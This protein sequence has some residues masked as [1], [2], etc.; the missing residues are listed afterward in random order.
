MK[1]NL[2]KKDSINEESSNININEIIEEKNKILE[3]KNIEENSNKISLYIVTNNVENYDLENEYNEE[4]LKKLL[5]PKETQRYFSKNNYPTFY[6]IGLQEIVKLNTSN[7]I[8]A[9]N[10]NYVNLWETKI[11]QLLQKNYNYT[12][13]YKE[14]LVGV[15][16]LFFIKASEAKN[17]ISTK[18]SIKKSGFLNFFGNKGSLF[19][20]LT[21]KN[22]NFAFCTGHLT[23]GGHSKKYN[24]RMKQLIDILNH[25]NDKLSNRF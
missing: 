5:F 15:L 4:S 25:Q 2:I 14:N 11:K 7:I 10:K 20:E 16:F 3:L 19:Y 8:F 9:A 22:K 1:D 18:K 6:C 24:E 13:Q 23:A 17:I 12:L 21:Y